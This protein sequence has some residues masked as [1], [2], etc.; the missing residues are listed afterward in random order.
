[1]ISTMLANPVRSYLRPDNDRRKEN[2]G[3]LATV[4]VL[5]VLVGGGV[6]IWRATHKAPTAPANTGTIVPGVQVK[7][8]GDAD[9]L[10]IDDARALLTWAEQQLGSVSDTSSADGAL[11]MLL[12]KIP[13]DKTRPLGGVMF[14]QFPPPNDEEWS[15]IVAYMQQRTKGD[16][17]SEIDEALTARGL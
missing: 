14:A 1:M 15:D 7:A 4:L 16:A 10:Q 2:P 11:A 12:S 17:L 13:R 8:F 5:G 6:L 3:A 9:G